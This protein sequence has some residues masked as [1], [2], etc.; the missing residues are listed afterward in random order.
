MYVIFHLEIPEL[1]IENK[2]FTPIAL[3]P[4]MAFIK[5]KDSA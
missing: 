3:K 1:D 2:P 4:L 5:G